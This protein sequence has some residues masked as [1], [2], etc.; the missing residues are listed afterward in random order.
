MH[1]WSEPA[2]VNPAMK[3]INERKKQGQL[4]DTIKAI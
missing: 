2:S 1:G 3:R 4:G